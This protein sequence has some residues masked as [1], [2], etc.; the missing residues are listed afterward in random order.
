MFLCS[1]TALKSRCGAVPAMRNHDRVAALRS[2]MA[3][4]VVYQPFVS[5]WGSRS[6]DHPSYATADRITGG[7][8]AD[9]PG[10]R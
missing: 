7:D 4:G 5:Q 8:H 10:R 3:A 2:S 9:S 6:A 1:R